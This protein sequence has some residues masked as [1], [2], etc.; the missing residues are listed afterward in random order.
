LKSGLD[1]FLGMKSFIQE[2]WAFWP[3]DMILCAASN[4]STMVT[5]LLVGAGS[6]VL[7]GGKNSMFIS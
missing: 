6:D 1:V 7:T 2:A 3:L 5:I 4:T